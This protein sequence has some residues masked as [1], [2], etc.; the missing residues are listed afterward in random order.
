MSRKPIKSADLSAAP[1]ATADAG[2]VGFAPLPQAER[3]P[4]GALVADA[5]PAPI[6]SASP[7]VLD[8]HGHDP[9]AYQWV[10][11]LR[12]RRADGWSPQKQRDYIETLADTGLVEDSARAVGMSVASCYRLRRAPGAES[13]AAAWDAAIHQA[14]RKLVDIAFDRAI[15]GSDEPVFDKHGTRVGRRMK[16]NDRLL[17]FLLRTHLPGRYGSVRDGHREPAP[18][19]C[20]ARGRGDRDAGAGRASRPASADVARSARGRARDRRHG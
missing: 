20:P 15:N 18:P 5:D 16:T 6:A 4:L 9:A 12:K 2:P 19:L 1:I 13:F 17:M 7:P 3:P 10:P 11:V 14:S 8:D